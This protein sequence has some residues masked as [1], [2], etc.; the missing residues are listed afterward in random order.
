MK[1]AVATWPQAEKQARFAALQQEAANT[2]NPLQYAG[3]QILNGY[4]LDTNVTITYFCMMGLFVYFMARLRVAFPKLI[5]VQV[6]ASIVTVIYLNAAPLL[7]TFDGTVAKVIVIPCSVAAGIGLVCNILVFPTSSTSEALDG[8]RDILALMPEFLDACVLGLR[9]TALDMSEA[10]LTGLQ[11]KVLSTYKLLGPPFRLL[12]IDLSVG[13]WG[14]DDLS[15]L[16]EPF[17]RLTMNFIA[18]TDLY[19]QNQVRKEKSID[20]LNRTRAGNSGSNSDQRTVELGQHQID[21]AVDFHVRSNYPSRNV[22]IKEGIQSLVNPG[23]HLIEVC[24]ES[25]QAISEALNQ[26]HALR[27][28][29]GRLDMQQRHAA[30]L[31]KL[32]EQRDIFMTSTSRSLPEI[33]RKV[34]DEDG[35]LRGETG[36]VSSFTGLMPGILLQEHLSRLADAIAQVL[37]RIVQLEGMRTKVRVWFPSRLIALL[38]W[39]GHED[40]PEDGVTAAD[41]GDSLTRISTVTSLRP[42]VQAKSGTTNPKPK[43]ARAELVSIR[44]P[45][46]PQEKPRG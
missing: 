42:N 1:A 4:M 17:R 32:C 44:A 45:N 14:S 13:R 31:S 19:R 9:H 28:N 23:E 21:R 12:P 2:T 27:K 18:L 34:F 10:K 41:L 8:M 20:A 43:S 15:T 37:T 33:S 35:L 7:P 16:N 30:V 39:V 6:V 24:K 25:L 29:P 38:R 40:S 3:V 22:L 11:T 36:I 5:L 26:A 46:G